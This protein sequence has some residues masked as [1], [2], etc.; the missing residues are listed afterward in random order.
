[1]N[2]GWHINLEKNTVK[3]TS[4]VALELYKCG[5]QVCFAWEDECNFPMLEGIIYDGKLVFNSDHMEHMD[6]VWEDAIQEVLKKHRVKGDICFSSNDGDNRGQKWGYRF[7]GEGGMVELK[8]KAI[9]S[10]VPKPKRA[11]RAPRSWRAG[12][13]ATID[14]EGFDYAFTHYSDFSEVKDKEF[15][16][17]L[18]AFVK[19]YG[20]LHDYVFAK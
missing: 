18:K 10:E 2:V 16:K 6:Y 9:Y 4:A 14:A 13:Q 3:I 1:M 12:V 15:Q 8:G 19:A 17:R 5:A 20:E 11:K 7:D